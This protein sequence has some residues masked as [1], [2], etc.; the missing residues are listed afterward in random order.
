MNSEA[1][2]HFKSNQSCY[3]G[4]TGVKKYKN[5]HLLF[6]YPDKVANNNGIDGYYGAK[7]KAKIDTLLK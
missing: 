6:F 4:G 7:T 5:I 2:N 1:I 3:K